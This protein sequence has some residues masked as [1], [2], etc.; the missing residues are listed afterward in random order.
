MDQKNLRIKSFYGTS[1]CAV[2]KQIGV[3]ISVDALAAVVKKELKTK[4]SLVG[5]RRVLSLTLFETIPLKQT[6]S[7]PDRPH[8]NGPSHQQCRLC[9]I[10]QDSNDSCYRRLGQFAS[11]RSQ[12]ARMN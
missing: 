4:R 8:Q 11:T 3:A 9:D 1:E 6:F 7:R 12:F 5:S 10:Y 2:Q